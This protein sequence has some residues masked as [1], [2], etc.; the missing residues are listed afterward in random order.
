MDLAVFT[1]RNETFCALYASNNRI[2]ETAK[3]YEK[4]VRFKLKAKSGK[5]YLMDIANNVPREQTLCMAA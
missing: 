4:I 5:F 3:R 2:G 1:V